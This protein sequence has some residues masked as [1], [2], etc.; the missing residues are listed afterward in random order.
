MYTVFSDV[1]ELYPAATGLKLTEAWTLMM[2][3]AGCDYAF[4]RDSDG[5]M[6]LLLWN[7]AE[8]IAEGMEEPMNDGRDWSGYSSNF[9]DNALARVAIMRHFVDQEL[10]GVQLLPDARYR[11]EEAHAVVVEEKFRREPANDTQPAV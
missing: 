4:E 7:N 10:R 8:T 11:A 2:A 1:H 5:V 6:R 3:L 9:P